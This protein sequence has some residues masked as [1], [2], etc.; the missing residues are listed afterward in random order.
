MRLHIEVTQDDIDRATPKDRQACMV[1]RAIIRCS[2]GVLR[3][4]VL[5]TR[6]NL[7]DEKDRTVALPEALRW[8]VKR[9]DNGN[10]DHE[11]FAFDIDLDKAAIVKG[12]VKSATRRGVRR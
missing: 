9:F 4:Q 3:P 1:A 6:M 12:S 7:G 5:W 11:P 8:R 2:E 10:R